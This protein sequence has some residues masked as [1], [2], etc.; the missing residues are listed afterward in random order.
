MSSLRQVVDASRTDIVCFSDIFWD[1]VWQR[2]QSLLTRF[3][4]GWNI[5]F[6]EPTSLVVLLKEPRRLFAR[7]HGNITVVSS[8]ALPLTDKVSFLR[9]V[10]DILIWCWLK[11]MFLK[12][13]VTRP[14]LLYYAPR[15][16]SLIGRLGERLAAY[17]CADDRMAFSREPQ[18]MGPYVENLFKKSG[19]VFVT[20]ERLRK[21]AL[22]YRSDN[23]HLIGNGVDAG[24]FEK[25]GGGMPVPDDIKEL[26][27][28]VIGYFGVI[29]EWMDTDLIVELASAYPEASIVLVGP[30]LV[31]PEGL[32]KIK[33]LS[34]IYLPGQKPH[35][36]LPGY[37]KAFDV[38]IIPFRLN[39]LTKSVNPVKL[40]EYLAGGKNIVT[41]TMAE[42]EKY[43]GTIYIARDHDDF[44]RKTADALRNKP[45]VDR[46]K[47]VVS[48]N[49]WDSKAK[50]MVEIIQ[51]STDTH[52]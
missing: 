39:E 10:N 11:A 25:A 9:P 36:A 26:K 4:E 44:I 52:G 40:Y 2:H 41:I 24:L 19:I 17:D 7:K 20:S 29:D 38:C 31:G 14:V 3:P 1:F 18:W 15:F 30:A 27:K 23:V 48:E 50:A 49:T 37:L 12:H 28:P 46:M 43:D 6:V 42:V 33:S 51:G 32:Q 21:K 13:K 8:P 45:D 34:N 22:G 5:L 47:A 35:D 16:S